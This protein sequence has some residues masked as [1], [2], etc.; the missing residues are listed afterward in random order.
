MRFPTD[1]GPGLPVSSLK[2]PRRRRCN[3]DGLA[4][5]IGS[6]SPVGPQVACA[7]GL[8]IRWPQGQSAA[9]SRP[10]HDPQPYYRS[11][12]QARHRQGLDPA[13]AA[14]SW[15]FELGLRKVDEDELYAALVWLRERQGTIETTLAKRRLKGGMLVLYDV[16]LSYVERRRCP[17]AKRGYNRDG[18]KGKAQIV[19][20]LLCA[21]DG[22]PVAIEVFEGDT[23]D[24]ATV[25]DQIVK[26]RRR[27]ALGRVVLVGDRA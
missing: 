26:L 11:D 16:S 18:K 5:L 3:Q 1:S 19:Y 8:S 24:P 27:F 17:S 14:S 15:G 13:A 25:A 21:A 9:R 23:G 4:R 6:S 22:C 12:F 7:A 2:R 10:G 20:G